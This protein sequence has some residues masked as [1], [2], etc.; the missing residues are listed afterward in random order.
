MIQ[1][2]VLV[3]LK[4]AFA[5]DEQRRLIA[6]HTRQVLGAVPMVRELRVGV[7][8]EDRSAR[9]FDLALLLRFDDLDAVEEWRTEKTHRA[10]V[11]V[12]L[13]PM[14]DKIRLWNFDAG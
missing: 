6:E 8:A 4:P 14:T 13:R 10:Y 7:V 5:T 3:K 12:Y 1:R 9:E 2:V 11:D